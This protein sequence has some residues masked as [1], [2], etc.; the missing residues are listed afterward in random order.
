MTKTF[1]K[2]IFGAFCLISSVATADV[3]LSDYKDFQ[4]KW[5]LITVRFREDSG[6]MR[7]T[8]GND[9]AMV[10]LLAGKG[11]YEDGAVFSKVGFKSEEDPSFISS[12]VPSGAR[13]VQLMIRDKEKYAS[14]DGWGYFLFDSAA[15]P[16]KTDENACAAC[17]RIVPERGYVFSQ[18]VAL[19]NLFK[20]PTSGLPPLAI[21]PESVAFENAKLAIL[22]AQFLKH[23]AEGKGTQGSRLIKPWLPAAFEGTADEIRPLLTRETLKS[24]KPSFFLSADSRV[25]SY[26][27]KTKAKKCPDKQIA[28]K[29]IIAF[30]PSSVAGVESELRTRELIYCAQ[31]QQL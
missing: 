10:G 3:S 5:P 18:K 23:I 1:I 2:I 7:F 21:N 20:A 6:E 14:T 11:Q 24:G 8:W 12:K 30:T 13:R 29:G 26:V 17:H 31:P 25:L 4:T 9:K 15:K 27:A 16:V 28:L 22:P 19:E